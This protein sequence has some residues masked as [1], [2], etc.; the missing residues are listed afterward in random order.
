M[1]YLTLVNNVLR[2]LREDEITTINQNAYAALIGSFVND[3]K[4]SVE[5][6]WDWT[7][8]RNTITVTTV[9]GVNEYTLSGIGENFKHLSFLDNTN[10]KS[11]VYQAKD[12]IDVQNNI[13]DTPL[14]GTPVYFSYTTVS[15]TGDMNIILYPT[16]AGEYVLKFNAVV[17][18][19]PLA[20]ASDVIKIPWIP[21]MHLALALSTRERGETGGTSAAEFFA[22]ADKYLGDAIAFDASYHPEETVFRVV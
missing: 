5:Q 15:S 21:V 8:L 18:Q 14:Q 4:D 7:A 20:L 16:P 9:A 13:T 19:A 1:N 17:R 12:W 10:N 22:I 6:A 3:A 11:I 2:R